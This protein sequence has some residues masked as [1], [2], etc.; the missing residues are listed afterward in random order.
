[1]TGGKCSVRGKKFPSLLHGKL[2]VSIP[3]SAID[4]SKP[5]EAKM[6][7]NEASSLRDREVSP[8]DRVW[9]QTQP[10]VFRS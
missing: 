4:A 10:D 2:G 1:L 9:S 6:E 7:Q 5:G 8:N 3:R